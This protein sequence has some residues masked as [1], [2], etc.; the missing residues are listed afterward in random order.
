LGQ[1]TE[2]KCLRLVRTYSLNESELASDGTVS[3]VE[4]HDLEGFRKFR[5]M[6]MI[7]NRLMDIETCKRCG[8]PKSLRL[9]F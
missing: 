5:K 9:E 8:Q 3:L 1:L 7:D 6:A 2:E 4:G